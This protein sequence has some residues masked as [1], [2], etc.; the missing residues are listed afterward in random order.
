MQSPN[1]LK[2]ENSSQ[3]EWAHLPVPVLCLIMDNLSEPIYHAW[4]A[5]VCKQW[6]LVA[7]D[8]NKKKKALP[9]L[10]LSLNNDHKTRRVLYGIT[11]G[12]IFKNI[13]LEVF[14]A[15][16]CCGFSHGWLAT[17]D[18]N[19]A[20]TLLNPFKKSATKITLPSLKHRKRIKIP[21]FNV[22]KVILSHNPTSSQDNYAVVV[23]YAP[24]DLLAF[25][26]PTQ[27]YAWTYL[28]ENLMGFTDITF[29]GGLVYA[30]GR[31][32]MVVSF[33]VNSKKYSSHLQLKPNIIVPSCYHRTFRY[34]ERVYIVESM[35]G[36]LLVVRRFMERKEGLLEEIEEGEEERKS[37]TESF[38]V[39]KLLLNDQ[40]KGSLEEHVEVKSL[41]DEA[42]FV[43]DNQSMSILAS[44]FPGCQP[45]SIYFTDDSIDVFAIKNTYCPKG[46]FD[47]G[48]Y[49]LE[50]GTFQKHY[51]P[52][53]KHR[54]LAPPL[55]VVPPLQ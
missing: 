20:I 12:K 52:E 28:D 40:T 5:G 31:R 54:Y 6:H 13:N 39:H 44:N 18:E 32:G 14:Y 26:N 15:R 45:N 17:V 46:P 2:P 8:Y 43:G 38:K 3:P 9:M 35:K 30:V 25:I 4:F 51:T 48:I 19:M 27:Q 34:A 23:I 33:D 42:L 16:R 47:M 21:Q 29:Y 55:W 7:K 53:Y 22:L 37:V 49:C 36:D 24:S 1:V 41:G 11:E 10:L 50:N